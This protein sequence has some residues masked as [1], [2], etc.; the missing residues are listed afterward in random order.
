MYACGTFRDAAGKLGFDPT[1]ENE[2]AFVCIYDAAPLT[3]RLES[4]P[5][6]FLMPELVGPKGAMGVC[7]D[8]GGLPSV[9]WGV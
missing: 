7:E 6:R 5:V 4:D 2:R 1:K 9:P 8:T 3:K